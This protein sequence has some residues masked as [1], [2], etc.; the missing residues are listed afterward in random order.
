MYGTRPAADG[1]YCECSE[2]VEASGFVRGESSACVFRHPEKNLV[3]SVHGDDFT[4]VGPKSSLDWFRQQLE[5]KYELKEASRLGPSPEDDKEGRVLNRI[6][7]WTEEGLEYEGDPRH[8]EKLLL[9]LGLKG[10]KPVSTP[11]VKAS[12]EQHHADEAL[13]DSKVTH[14]RG[15]AARS[16]YLSADK[17]NCKFSAKEVCRSMAKPTKLSV[18]GFKPLGRYLCG[19]KRLVYVYRWQD[20][21]DAVDVY[22]DTDHAGC[23]RTRKSTSG[24]CVMLGAHLLKSWASTQPTITLSSGEAELHGVVKGS[25]AGL[26]MVS[27]LADLGVR[28]RL[29]VWTDSTASIGICK[30]QGLGKVR[31]LD[32]QDLWFQQRVRSGDF[33]LYKQIQANAILVISLPSSVFL[34]RGSSSWCICW[35]ASS[36]KA[37]L[38]LL[39]P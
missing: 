30:R 4:T 16:N 8:V 3:A 12:M 39:Q 24:G 10:A 31:H 20:Q 26:G 18:E 6:V 36:E 23:L 35:A 25:A 27:L 21:V 32:V 1:W 19:Q 38:D 22:V 11:G 33:D 9:E 17:P 28:I 29:R 14:F 7:R 15:L 34:R 37:E 2:S 5:S 13:P